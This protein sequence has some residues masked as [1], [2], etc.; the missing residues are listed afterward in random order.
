MATTLRIAVLPGDGDLDLEGVIVDV[1]ARPLVG[2]DRHVGGNTFPSA[3]PSAGRGKI[4]FIQD[5]L[6][7]SRCQRCAL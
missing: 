6:P 5:G 4:Q 7:V 3:E 2:A 1:G